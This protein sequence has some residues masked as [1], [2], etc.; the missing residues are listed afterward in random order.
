MFIPYYTLP[1]LYKTLSTQFYSFI[2]SLFPPQIFT[3]CFPWA[4]HCS[5]HWGYGNKGDKAPALKELK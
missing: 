1:G 5:G 2:H 4:R 3:E